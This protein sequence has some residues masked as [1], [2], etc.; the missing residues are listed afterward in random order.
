MTKILIVNGANLNQ[1]GLRNSSNYGYS[2]L[3]EIVE[4]VKREFPAIDFTFLQSNSEQELIQA[5]QKADSFD[6]IIINPGG[7]THSSVGLRDALETLSIPKIEVHLSNL[8][9]REQF[10]TTMLTTSKCDGY[11]SGFKE[12][13]YLSAVY[14]LTKIIEGTYLPARLVSPDLSANKAGKSGSE[15]AGR[16]DS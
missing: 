2:S 6:G 16:F 14:T 3:N 8:S 12:L 4:K 1:L 10:R 7:F 15:R 9:S 11:I 5:V 13:G